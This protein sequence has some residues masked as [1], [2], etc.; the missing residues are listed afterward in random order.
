MNLQ[1]LSALERFIEG[2]EDEGVAV[3]E[4]AM[5]GHRAAHALAAAL[6]A[7]VPFPRRTTIRDH[8]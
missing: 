3:A 8:Y 2:F 1:E 5:D 6:L 4:G 7:A